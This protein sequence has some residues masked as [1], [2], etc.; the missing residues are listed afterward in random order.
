[1]NVNKICFIIVISSIII[2]GGFIAAAKFTSH[3][4]DNSR[5]DSS[6]ESSLPES[7]VIDDSVPDDDT[8][9][10]SDSQSDND[11][12]PD[13]SSVPDDSSRSQA[14]SEVL[15]DGNGKELPYDVTPI[16]EAFKTG[17]DTALN[18]KEYETLI[19]AKKVIDELITYDM[20]D[21]DKAKAVHDYV[22]RNNVYND[23]SLNALGYSSLDDSSPYGVL[24]NHTSVC[25][26][27]AT[28]FQLLCNLCG[29]ECELITE[30]EGKEIHHQYDRLKLDGSWYYVDPTWDDKDDDEY[31]YQYFCLT[32]EQMA[33]NHDLD[34]TCPET[35]SDINTY[36]YHSI[37]YMNDT[38]ELEKAIIK[39]QDTDTPSPYYIRVGKGLGLDM[40]FHDDAKGFDYYF[41]DSEG[42]GIISKTLRNT[43]PSTY[44][45]YAKTII[46]GE[47][48]LVIF[49]Y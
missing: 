9:S 35:D 42:I 17:D 27:Y 23:N 25:K 21:Y 40:K 29:I 47:L 3:S 45:E 16:V 1:M 22:V 14:G 43:E 26:G 15:R 6:Y 37:I 44:Y 33:Y 48:L 32:R 12:S 10:V 7:S 8:S 4:D 34:D 46:D 19:A 39:A 49:A 41:E 31:R 5:K 36:A 11:S 18:D 38:D 13:D 24:I 2:G 20:T 28:A 30:Y